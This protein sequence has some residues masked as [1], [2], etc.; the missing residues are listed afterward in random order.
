MRKLLVLV[1]VAL[2]A[3][4]PARAATFKSMEPTVV[5]GVT[6]SW[7]YQFTFK[8]SVLAPS[9]IVYGHQDSCDR[10]MIADP[11][12]GKPTNRPGIPPA[13]LCFKTESEARIEAQKEADQFEAN[14]YNEPTCST[15]KIAA[16]HL[17]QKLGMQ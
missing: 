5:H 11:K 13:I 10:P 2:F 4:A 8:S 3:A 12:T 6:I 17:K 1:F 7:E 14:C 9:E 15:F 16:K